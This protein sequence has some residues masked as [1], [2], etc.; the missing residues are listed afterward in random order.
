MH[1]S[2]QLL[3]LYGKIIFFG[4]GCLV[5]FLGASPGRNLQLQRC[6]MQGCASSKSSR[7]CAGNMSGQGKPVWSYLVTI[8]VS[9]RYNHIGLP[10]S[11]QD[12]K[13]PMANDAKVPCD[14]L[15][16]IHAFAKH[17]KYALVTLDFPTS[18]NISSEA[19]A[20]VCR[21]VLLSSGSTQTSAGISLLHFVDSVCT[22]FLFKTCCCDCFSISKGE[23]LVSPTLSSM[24]MQWDG[25]K[26]SWLHLTLLWCC[27]GLSLSLSFFLSPSPCDWIL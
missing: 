2:C 23:I 26:V 17:S 13:K 11:V 27:L 3:V 7:F 25:W 19:M 20:H 10:R 22:S 15:I 9:K 21:L 16:I 4:V 1:I 5:A 8:V 14:Q 6:M 12:G 24:K 18:T